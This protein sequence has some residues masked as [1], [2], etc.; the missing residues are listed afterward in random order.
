MSRFRGLR[1]WRVREML[2]V[3]VLLSG[4]L[5]LGSGAAAASPSYDVEAV[6]NPPGAS[7]AGLFGISCPMVAGCVA[8]GYAT[9]SPAGAL[10]ET[11]TGGSWTPTAF[12]QGLPFPTLNAVWC[13][14]MT[15]CVAVGAAGELTS[16]GAQPLVE[17]LSHGTW[18]PT[19]PPLPDTG[20]TGSLDAISCVTAQWCV[21]AGFLRDSQDN[22]YGLFEVL[23]NGTWIPEAGPTPSPS[24]QSGIR[25]VQCFTTT[26]CDAVGFYGD[27]SSSNG[28]LETLS[29][30]T[31][32]G[33][34]LGGAG[35]MD[36]LSCVSSSSCLA[37]GSKVHGGG[38]TETWSGATWTGGTLP[39]PG[40][41][42]GNG[43]A[44]V[45]CPK[46]VLSCVA[47]G[48]WHDPRPHHYDPRLL[49]ETESHGTWT[50][51]EIPAPSGLMNAQGIACPKV[52]ACVGIG[53]SDA[54]GGPADA[55]IEQ[56]RS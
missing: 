47:I 11:Y 48:G 46:S 44:G 42:N 52:S 32:A 15:S 27:L 56:P 31:W 39:R 41:G 14:S 16:N 23:S 6:P 43:M 45:S 13:A 10:V 9:P 33:S 3:L 21:A 38:Y 37:V 34:V 54:N 8:V 17:T 24:T 4:V 30:H 51:T 49:I 40:A 55:A 28:L 22:T 53:P 7:N 12:R 36:S 25:S 20:I 35:I 5:G 18:T 19:S 50:P 2:A 1:P 26:S 29:G